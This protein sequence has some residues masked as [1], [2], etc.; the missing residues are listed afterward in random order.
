M[1][2]DV[3]FSKLCSNEEYVSI[4][5]AVFVCGQLVAVLRL[6][7]KYMRSADSPEEER[8][9]CVKLFLKRVRTEIET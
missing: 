4:N 5:C 9:L 2:G 3:S 7:R 8:D 6:R 1:N